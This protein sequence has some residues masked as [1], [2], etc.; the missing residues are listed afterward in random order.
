ML[1]LSRKLNESIMI[2]DQVEI[3]VLEIRDNYVKLGIKAPREVSVH[4]QEV[5]QE[6]LEENQR[7]RQLGPNAQV[8]TAAQALRKLKKQPEK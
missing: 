2:G 8:D 4:R 6:I 3:M 5:H 7:A 1:V